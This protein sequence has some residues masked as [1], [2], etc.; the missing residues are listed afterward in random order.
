MTEFMAKHS[1]FN[2]CAPNIVK[3]RLD[4]VGTYQDSSSIGAVV[5][6]G[7]IIAIQKIIQVVSVRPDIISA[8]FAARTIVDEE[9]GVH[10]AVI[11][12]GIGD[13]IWTVIV[14]LTEIYGGV[15]PV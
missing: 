13:A 15:G 8:H 5:V 4:N 12:A 14:I 10:Y 2:H 7:V 3:R 9:Y 6:G 1:N 11:I